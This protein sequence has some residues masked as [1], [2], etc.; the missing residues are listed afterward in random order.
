MQGN[1]QP[2]VRS[3]N[4]PHP[5]PAMKPAGRGAW[6]HSRAALDRLEK[7][8]R[9]SR[10][11]CVSDCIGS[12]CPVC[13]T[14]AWI[15]DV[16]INRQL[17]SMI[18][19]CSKLQ[20]LLHDTD[21]SDLKEKTSRKSLFND[22][23]SKKNSIKMWFSPR[24]KKVRY[25][26]SKLSVQTQPS[27]KNDENA[28][29]TSMYEFV[30]PSPPVEVSEGP[31]KPSTRSRKKQKK[32]TLAEVNR[33]WNLEAEKEDGDLDCKGE[34]KEKLVSFC[35][36][37]S[38]IANLQINGE[39]DLLASGSVTESECLDEVFLPLAEHIESPEIESKNEVVTPEK[40]VSAN[41]L[42]SKKS[43]PSGRNGKRGRH[44]R[45]SSPV[46]KRC[47]SSSQSTGGNS[48]KQTVL[49]ENM[50][51]LGCSS[52]PS[53]KLKVGDT[54]SR[55]SRTILDESISLSPGTPPSTLNS[56]SYRRMMCSPSATK[57]WPISHT[58]VKRNHRGETLLHIASIKGD[59]P[60]VEYLLQSGSDPNV[61]DHAGW[62]PLHEACNHGHLKVVE[63]LLQHKAL[64]NTTGYQ[65]DSPL[66]D[67]VKNG[68]VDI[69]KLLLTYG[70]SR[71]A[72]NIF[73]LRPVDY[74]D[75]EN[76]K[77]LLLLPEKK[78]SS[79]TSH[80]SVVN[81]GQRRDGPLVLIGS[82]LSSE[83]QKMLSELATILKAKKC[84]EFDG[85]VT[86]VIVPGDT[87]QSTLKCMLGIL[88]GCWILKFEW[89][90][91]CLQS[92]E[93]EQEEKYEIPEGPQKSRLN[94]E[95]LL[96][97]LFDGCYFY[98]GGTFKHHP[99]D[100]LIKLVA[101]GGGQIL[102]RKP[103]PDSDVTQT[104]NTVAYHAKPDSDQ[105]FCTQYII[106][107]DL[108]NHRPERVRQGKV[109]MAPSSW[110]IDC[111]MSFELLPLDN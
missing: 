29:Q 88:S 40:T 32:K 16:K 46:S 105:R 77:S 63:L 79:S 97:K 51:L 106:Y 59:I 5:A 91:A 2:R 84:A 11:N 54:L 73:G 93:C 72:V 110:F 17:D 43:L 102:I 39:I 26:V 99:K 92:K 37:P 78:E 81:T 7:L 108:S 44:N 56:P 65:N 41:Y 87:V 86:H 12:E 75:S 100:N 67:A 19:L 76:M 3:G 64:V 34:S 50:P 33:K 8:L 90:K 61:K 45:I 25:T 69:V 18:Q 30:S 89:V 107:E 52:P 82:G 14:P 103:K 104:I 96:P 68:H 71:E 13:Y 15:Q 94:R 35:S 47:R 36:Q 66:H 101:A 42:P 60:S 48:V 1:R 24:S 22:A 74:A 109:W 55:N 20:N 80:C 57:L 111:V 27:V 85:T 53:N 28:Q 70:A 62:T 95:Q 83:Q 49:L 4:Q 9:C 31:K 98:L 10:C 58:A 38:V 23:Q 6:A 21:L